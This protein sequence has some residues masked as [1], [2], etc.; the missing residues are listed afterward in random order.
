M[1]RCA[2][3]REARACQWRYEGHIATHGPTE[4]RRTIDHEI[5]AVA[6]VCRD[7]QR[8]GVREPLLDPP[9]L[10]RESTNQLRTVRAFAT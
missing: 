10:L 9:L 6:I 2:R 4:R 1:R 8:S 7:A 3:L 5:Q